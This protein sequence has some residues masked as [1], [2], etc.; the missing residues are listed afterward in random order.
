MATLMNGAG[1]TNGGNEVTTGQVHYPQEEPEVGV[2]S[3][4]DDVASYLSAALKLTLGAT[5]QELERDDGPLAQSQAAS[6]IETFQTF[7]VGSRTAFYAIKA[8]GAFQQ[9]GKTIFV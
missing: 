9:D 2:Q 7:L 1:V 5:Q 3:R 6:T 8:E 4:N